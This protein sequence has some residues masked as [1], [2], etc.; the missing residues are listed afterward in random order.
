MSLYS[1]NLE[2]RL[3]YWLF[4]EI[5]RRFSLCFPISRLPGYR[6]SISDSA[7]ETFLYHKESRLPPPIQRGPGTLSPGEKRLQSEADNS[8]PS[9]LKV[10][11]AYNHTSTLPYVFILWCLIKNFI[12]TFYGRVISTFCTFYTLI[13]T[14]V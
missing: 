5:F 3:G 8:L 12:F 6:G 13:C 4:G 7:K 11:N 9:S 1:G 14:I 2:Y 10:N